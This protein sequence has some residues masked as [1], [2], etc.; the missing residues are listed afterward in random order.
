MYLN[1]LLFS[2]PGGA[3]WIFILLAFAVAMASLGLW[4]YTIVDIVR[5]TFS[6]D[7]TKIVWLLVVVLTGILGSILYLIFGRSGR[8]LPEANN[9]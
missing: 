7:T 5:N 4:I 6:D 8:I 1:Q 9:M 3:E 2:M